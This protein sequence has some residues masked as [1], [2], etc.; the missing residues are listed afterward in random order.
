MPGTR[1]QGQ[2][3]A[4]P[5]AQRGK[6]REQRLAEAGVRRT[7]KRQGWLWLLVCWG[8]R[9]GVS[10]SHP[11]LPT[12]HLFGLERAVQGCVSFPM[13]Q[14]AG[15]HLGISR[16]CQWVQSSSILPGTPWHWGQALLKWQ[17]LTQL[18]WGDEQVG[19]LVRTPPLLP[20]SPP[21]L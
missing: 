14:L 21:D 11:R 16:G 2:S 17:R 4:E 9:Q 13:T 8:V 6:Q 5:Q 20:L 1:G 19:E 7:R 3:R 18:R 10:S 12:W 15:Y